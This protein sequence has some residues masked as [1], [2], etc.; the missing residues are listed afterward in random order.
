M[1]ANGQAYLQYLKTSVETT[2][3]GKL[4]LMLFDGAIKNLN[5]AKNAIERKDFNLAHNNIIATQD[6][7]AELITTLRMDYEISTKLLALYE[8]F[9]QQLIKA[10]IKKDTVLIDE[11]LDY[12]VE[13]H[14][15]WEQAIKTLGPVVINNETQPIGRLNISG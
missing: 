11:V 10:N 3:P 15:T 6:I 8:Y 1:G 2:S 13:M 5:T 9:M 14:S 4:L 12:F 7:V